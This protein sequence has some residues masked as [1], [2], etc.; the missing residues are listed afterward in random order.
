MNFVCFVHFWL[1]FWKTLVLIFLH[2]IFTYYRINI[3]LHIFKKDLLL[4]IFFFTFLNYTKLRI[5]SFDSRQNVIL[6]PLTSNPGSAPYTN[7]SISI[8]RKRTN[9]FTIKKGAKGLITFF[10]A[11]ISNLEHSP[12]NVLFIDW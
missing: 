7:I 3:Y 10:I 4:S 9:F 6:L 11:K 2:I 5:S 1:I 12:L 8:R